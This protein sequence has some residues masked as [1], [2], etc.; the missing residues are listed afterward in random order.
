MRDD[1]DFVGGV[2]DNTLRWLYCDHAG[3]VRGTCVLSSHFRMLTL[4]EKTK[5]SEKSLPLFQR[6][7]TLST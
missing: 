4:N 3:N 6:S 5:G 7:T 2:H 1:A